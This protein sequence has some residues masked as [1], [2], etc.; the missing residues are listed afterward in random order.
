MEYENDPYRAPRSYPMTRSNNTGWIIAAFV[1]VVAAIAVGLWA[2]AGGSDQ[3]TAT[4]ANPAGPT[5]QAT[6]KSGSTTVGAPAGTKPR[7][8]TGQAAAPNGSTTTGSV[9]P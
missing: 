3:R 1:V 4:S 9:K 8:T 2:F 5:G 7:E 6:S